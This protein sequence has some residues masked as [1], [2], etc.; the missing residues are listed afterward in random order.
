M[1][2]PSLF[3]LA[4]TVGMLTAAQASAGNF[5]AHLDQNETV[6]AAAV[7]TNATGQ[8]VIKVRSGGE[9]SFKVLVAGL[10]NV[11]AAHIHC[12]AAG[13]AGPIGVTLFLSAPIDVNGIL[14]QGPIEE[15]DPG[16]ACGWLDNFDVIDAIEAGDAYVN[17]HTLQNL[18]GELRGQLD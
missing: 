11:A 3:A 6:P 5:V 13:V 1:R 7:A 17:L 15:P 18:S 14:A 16:N 12:G 9:L 4:A 8:A 2:N 10:Q